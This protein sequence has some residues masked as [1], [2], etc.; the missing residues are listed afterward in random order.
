MLHP[1]KSHAH[2]KKD[3]SEGLDDVFHGDFGVLGW[4]LRSGIGLS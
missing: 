4:G 2:F 1:M 3:G